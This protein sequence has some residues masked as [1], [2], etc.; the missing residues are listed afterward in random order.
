[1]TRTVEDVNTITWQWYRGS[2]PITGA[3]EGE[4]SITSMYTARAR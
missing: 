4:N 2:N 3:N 1:M